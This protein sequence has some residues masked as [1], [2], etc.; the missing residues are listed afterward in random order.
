MTLVTV[1]VPLPVFYNPDATGNRRP[2]EEEKLTATAEEV[3]REFGGAVLWRFS[4]GS[5]PR[6]YWWNRE[7]LDIDVLAMLEVDVPDTRESRSWFEAYAETVLMDRF[8]QEAIY[9]KF[10][11]GGAA[12]ETMTVSKKPPEKKIDG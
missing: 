1:L 12:M 7:I 11:G 8:E 10:Y 5:G 3:A 6:G 2:I 9:L 4:E